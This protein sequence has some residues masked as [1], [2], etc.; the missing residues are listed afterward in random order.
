MNKKI[1]IAGMARQGK[2]SLCEILRDKYGLTFASSSYTAAEEFIFDKL[3]KEKHYQS[4]S[5]CFNDRHAGENRKLWFDLITEFNHEDPARLAKIITSK[6]DIYCG[7]RSK[8]ELEECMKQGV[9]DLTFW[10]DAS[11]RVS[12]RESPDSITISAK[13]CMHIIDNNG[14]LDDLEAQADKIYQMI[15][16]C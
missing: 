10:V 15:N 13:D 9:F 3:K 8:V 2:D 4:V 1:L 7:L 12:Y 11:D 16:L 6:N 14:T 5:Q